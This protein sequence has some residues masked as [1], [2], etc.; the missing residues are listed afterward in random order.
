MPSSTPT[1]SS[2]LSHNLQNRSLTESDY[3]LLL[4]LDQPAQVRQGNTGCRIVLV[5]PGDEVI[6]SLL[7]EVIQQ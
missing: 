7:V 4:R 3:E 2:S 5:N 1:V 6:V